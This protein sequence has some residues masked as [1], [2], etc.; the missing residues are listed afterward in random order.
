MNLINSSSNMKLGVG[1]V[2]NKTLMAHKSRQ[3]VSYTHGVHLTY[4]YLIE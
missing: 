2:P 1:V 4:M 3:H